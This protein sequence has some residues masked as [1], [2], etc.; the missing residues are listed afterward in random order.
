MRAAAPKKK[1]TK[2]IHPDF[3]E[4]AWFDPISLEKQRVGEES[5]GKQ[6]ERKAGTPSARFEES[7]QE[8][9][10]HPSASSISSPSSRELMTIQRARALSVTR[11]QRDRESIE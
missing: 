10:F 6:R 5:Q 11:N 3:P 7:R 4:S 9:F 8:G 1:A 2:A